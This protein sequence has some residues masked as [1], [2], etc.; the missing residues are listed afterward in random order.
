MTRIRYN[1][2]IIMLLLCFTGIKAQTFTLQGRVT[3]SEMNP[4]EL[5]TVAVVQQGKMTMTNL[6]GEFSMK[7]QSSDSVVVRFSMV[8]YK[9]KTRVLRRPKGKQT[10]LIQL[11]DDNQLAGVTVTEEKRQMGSTQ[12]LDT[13][14]MK[15]A[16]SVTGNAVEEMI[17]SQAGVSTHSELS[18]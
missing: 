10:L 8:G 15:N 6:K 16:P 4:V 1:I 14:D 17:Q 7:L 18:S 3:D 11:Y 12:K 5:A 9:T 2:I 13:K